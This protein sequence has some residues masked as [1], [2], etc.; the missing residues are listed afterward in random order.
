[1]SIFASVWVLTYYERISLFPIMSM[2]M[3]CAW[4]RS[5]VWFLSS[6]CKKWWFFIAFLCG[7][8]IHT[9]PAPAM[10]FFKDVFLQVSHFSIITILLRESA[11]T[12]RLCWIKY[13]YWVC[14]SVVVQTSSSFTTQFVIS[15]G[16]T[17]SNLYETW[18]QS[19]VTAG[20]SVKHVRTHRSA[21]ESVDAQALWARRDQ[22]KH[23]CCG[24]SCS[25]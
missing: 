25:Q 22:F 21:Y 6:S 8:L 19:N 18:N 14:S 20:L 11:G 15:T 16:S 12:W 23:G 5:R 13:E 4:F 17:S 10:S 7:N 2:L 1:M 24:M 9:S 3:N